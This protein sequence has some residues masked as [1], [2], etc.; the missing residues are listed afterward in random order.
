MLFYAS[1]TSCFIV[2]TSYPVF[3][4]TLGN[5]DINIYTAYFIVTAWI[6]TLAFGL[7]ITVFFS[8]HLWLMA[9]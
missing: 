7:L 3:L 2:V 4:A 1:V 6:L 8:F 9:N 5:D